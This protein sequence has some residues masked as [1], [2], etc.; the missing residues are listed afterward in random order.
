MKAREFT[1]KTFPL[2]EMGNQQRVGEVPPSDLCLQR[3]IVENRLQGQKAGKPIT[4]LL[5]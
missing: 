3:V 1:V 4:R 5:Q 2:M